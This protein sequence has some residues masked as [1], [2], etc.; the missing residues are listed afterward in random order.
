MTLQRL[1]IVDDDEVFRERL[2]RALRTRGYTV[3]TAASVADALARLEAEMPDAM[4]VDL[5]MPG[6][7]VVYPN[8]ADNFIAPKTG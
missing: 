7:S 4:V 8:S 3:Q 2:A 5:R 1:L 6:E